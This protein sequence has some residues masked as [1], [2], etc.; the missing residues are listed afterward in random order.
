MLATKNG[1]SLSEVGLSRHRLHIFSGSRFARHSGRATGGEDQ[2]NVPD[3]QQMPLVAALR[4]RA[5]LAGAN[6][7]HIPG[8]KARS[9]SRSGPGSQFKQNNLANFVCDQTLLKLRNDVHLLQMGS[10]VNDA[11]RQL[12]GSD[13][14]RHD[15]TE[16][17]GKDILL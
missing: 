2:R 7:F 15:M 9:D 10:G 6:P 4:D 12:L 16:L 11:F 1:Q 5:Q 14:L 8:H 3:H 13:A 17:D